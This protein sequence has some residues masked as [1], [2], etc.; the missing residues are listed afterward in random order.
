M[1]VLHPVVESV[2]RLGPVLG[3]KARIAFHRQPDDSRRGVAG[4]GQRGGDVHGIALLVP[5]GFSELICVQRPP[6]P[7]RQCSP[8]P[9]NIPQLTVARVLFLQVRGEQLV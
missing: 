5:A 9:R 8:Q 1:V 6:R 2:H 4:D 7:F 3:L